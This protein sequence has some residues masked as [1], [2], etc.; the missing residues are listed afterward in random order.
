MIYADMIN[1]FPE[2]LVTVRNSHTGESIIGL[3]D[4]DDFS[5]SMGAN[6]S[7]SQMAGLI[8]GGLKGFA[9]ALA[10]KALGG[11]GKDLVDGGFKTAF[12]TF[13]SY[14]DSQEMSYS[15]TM[16]IFP[17]KEN[18]TYPNVIE[19][20]AKLTQPDTKDHKFLTSYLYEP[21]ITRKLAKGEDP[22]K[23]QLIHVTIGKWFASTGLFCTGSSLQFAKYLNESGKP[24]YM[25]W[26]ATFTPY[27]TLNAQE[28]ARAHKI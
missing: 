25:V 18:G 20:I 24:L 4:N 16:H 12:S 17:D 6:L 7:G 13:K 3:I 21:S 15:I 22:F 2:Y 5:Y 14:E 8:E 10:G 28:V 11:V 9:S 26:D 1:Q 19:K 27:K 23:G